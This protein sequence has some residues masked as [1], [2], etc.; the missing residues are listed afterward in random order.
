ME[1]KDL[2]EA[3]QK[4]A[5]KLKKFIIAGVAILAVVLLFSFIGPSRASGPSVITGFFSFFAFAI[6]FIAIFA[7][8]AVFAT[9]KEG[10][11]YKKLYKAYFVER[12]LR[13]IFTDIYYNHE[14]GMP[15]EVLS[16]TNMMRTGDV[17]HS[18]DFTSGKYKDVS[19]AQAD[20]VIQEE[21]TDS[22]GDTTYVTIF[23]GRWMV[24]EFPK[25]FTFRLE[26]VQKWF[27]AHKKLRKS[28]E[29]NRK[30]VKISTESPTFNKKF[31]VY[32]E[33]GFEAYYILDPAFI[34]HIEKLSDAHKGK[35]LL[36]FI[37]N[38]LH[39]AIN[40]KKD[41]FEPGSPLKPID[42]QAENQKIHDD[43]KTITDFVEFL[44]LDRKLFKN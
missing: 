39:V 7:V 1:F 16:S 20:V 3:R 33:D 13:Q 26:V 38:K 12:N 44:K 31:K 37:D 21:H 32:A 43:I 5:S 23:K 30:I 22:D 14:Q 27:N 11:A 40:D 34:D 17:Y 42:E 29:A 15:K 25:P 4:Y 19:F 18:N 2:E 8:V 24:F 10:K 41:A 35:L 6:F 9:R 28:R 36:C